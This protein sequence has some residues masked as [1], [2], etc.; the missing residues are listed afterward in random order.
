MKKILMI[1][2]GGTIASIQTK[3]G[4]SPALTA[5]DLLNFVP[6]IQDYCVADTL[7]LMNIDSTNMS[8]DYWL[9][10]SNTIIENYDNYD[11]FIVCHGTDTM[12][13]T[14]AFLSYMIQ[15][16]PKPI[17]VTGSQKP[18]N[19]ENTDAKI[20]LLDSFTYACYEGAHDV[21]IVFGGSVIA[22]T[23]AK[24]MRTKAFNAFSSINFPEIAEIYDGK[25]IQYI[26]RK[27]ASKVTFYNKI[28]KKVGLLYLTPGIDSKILDSY[29]ECND[30]VVIS[31]Y[32]SG[33]LPSGGL[34]HF[35]DIIDSWQNKGKIL[36]MT[37]QV[38]REG[39]D[40]TIYKV[41]GEIKD[42]YGFIDAYDMTPE[43]IIPKLMWILGQTSDYREVEKLFYTTINFDILYKGSER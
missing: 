33:G 19:K 40:M 39:S 5:E 17:I 31:S 37:T 34:Y 4:L 14:A 10:I 13:Y 30:A 18:I 35:Y 38:T 8:P 15:N 2:T 41:G 3:E 12:A 25:I 42:K 36:V 9:E 43:S 22:G 6:S 27:P 26:D 32:G 21:N 28:N 16:S 23:R 7:P 29:L 1:T 24:K 11:G 20:N